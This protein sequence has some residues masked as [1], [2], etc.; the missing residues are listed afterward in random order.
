MGKTSGSNRNLDGPGIG[1]VTK[2]KG[3]SGRTLDGPGIGK[4]AGGGDH[5]N[6]PATSHAG[7]KPHP[8]FGEGR[9]QSYSNPKVK[10]YAQ[11]PQGKQSGGF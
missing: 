7:G 6:M 11:G 1:K 10:C 3:G 2:G 9:K 4:A 5:K 8:A